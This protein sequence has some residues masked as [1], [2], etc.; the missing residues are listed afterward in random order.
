M[1]PWTRKDLLDGCRNSPGWAATEAYH[2]AGF[3]WTYD[4]Q[5][6]RDRCFHWPAHRLDAFEHGLPVNEQDRRD[7]LAQEID[8]LA[9]PETGW[10]HFRFCSCWSCTRDGSTREDKPGDREGPESDGSALLDGLWWPL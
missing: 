4:E 3:V 9:A 1:E 10:R 2:R 8:P 6:D 5:L 7:M